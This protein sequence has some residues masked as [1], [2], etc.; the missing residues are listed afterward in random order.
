MIERNRSHRV[1]P[2]QV[3]LEGIVVSVP[4]DDIVW[5]AILGVFEGLAHVSVDDSPLLRSLFVRGNWGTEVSLVCKAISSN[6]SEVWNGKVA[7]VAF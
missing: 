2:V 6:G 7:G 4:C 5:T 3:I 1:E